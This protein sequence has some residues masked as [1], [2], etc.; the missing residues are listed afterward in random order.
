MA[1]RA[2]NEGCADGRLSAATLERRIEHAL[3]AE[4]ADELRQLTLDVQRLPRFR[5]W[6]TAWAK[7]RS[8]E[9]SGSG[10]AC[11]WLNG[12][13]QRP[14]LVGRSPDADLMLVDPAISRRHAQIV[15]TEEGFLLA[16]LRSVNGTWLG[17]RR[18]GQ[19]EIAVGDVVELG[20]VPLRLV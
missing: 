9:P 3:I 8:S 12:I 4:S 16:D 6:M 15:R 11:L 1:I 7:P 17:G 13:G 14:F 18:V 5:T 20:N 19:I 2:L 10:E